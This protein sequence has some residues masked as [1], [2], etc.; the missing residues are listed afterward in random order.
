MNTEERDLVTHHTRYW[1]AASNGQLLI[2][3][4][5]GCGEYFFY[6]RPICPLCASDQTEWVI[7]CGQG[8]VYAFSLMRRKGEIVSAPAFITLEEGP[9]IATGLLGGSPENYRVDMRVELTFA[10]TAEHPNTPFFKPAE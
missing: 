7:A 9:T 6:P 1:Q 8:R 3:R 2:K 4:C 5:N 10:A